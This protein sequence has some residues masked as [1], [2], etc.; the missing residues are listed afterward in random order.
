MMEQGEKWERGG[1]KDGGMHEE[2]KT[3]ERGNITALGK[4]CGEG[5]KVWHG[6]SVLLNGGR[7]ERRGRREIGRASCRE[8]V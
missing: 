5:D 6:A 8:R 2:G 4:G 7:E 1:R 3:G